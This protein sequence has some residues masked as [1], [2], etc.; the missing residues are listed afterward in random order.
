MVMEQKAERGPAH[1]AGLLE[2]FGTARLNGWQVA[3]PTPGIDQ[4]VHLLDDDER[5]AV[6]RVERRALLIAALAGGLSALASAVAEMVM[7]PWETSNVALFWGVIGGVTVVASVLEIGFLSFDAL[8]S[9]AG[10]ARAAGIRVDDEAQ[11]AEVVAS[12]A[13]AAL[14][15]PDPIVSPMGVDPLRESSRWALVL[16]ALVYKLKVSATNVL[17]KLVVRRALGRA[18][19]RAWL[20][21]LAI[22]GTAAW[23]AFVC[24]IVL[25]EA[26]VRIFGPSLVVDV[27]ERLLGGTKPVSSQLAEVCARAVGACI[28]RSADLHPNLEILLG[29]V[30]RRT[31]IARPADVDDSQR[32]LAL[33]PK[34]PES[35]RKD[36]FRMLTTAAVI[37]GR[38]AKREK[39][40]LAEA[41]HAA[42]LSFDPQIIEAERRCV[43]AGRP[44]ALV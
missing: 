16:A 4:P 19:V 38:L 1:K 13:R 44:L 9:V 39:R 42:G 12:L 36:A 6:V 5:R 14:E 18:V 23:N 37:D 21:L 7:Q 33:L 15:V 3:A 34:L 43:R 22:P 24:L 27:T 17:L 31:G 41:A 35:E 29:H 10:L 30:L 8:R 2:R 11:R 20:P 26:R 25:R 28:V 40:L 32:F